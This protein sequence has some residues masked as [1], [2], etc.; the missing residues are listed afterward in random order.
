MKKKYLFLI[1]FLP[2]VGFRCATE[3]VMEPPAK[4]VGYYE[5]MDNCEERWHVCIGEK[6]PVVAPKR[7]PRVVDY[8]DST[9]V[10][11]YSM[12]GVKYKCARCGKV[13]YEMEP[14]RR[15]VIWVK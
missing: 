13:V 10:L 12:H 14:D 9:V 15:E 4:G 6:V 8:K 5:R 7:N 11:H 3:K 2:F 1:L